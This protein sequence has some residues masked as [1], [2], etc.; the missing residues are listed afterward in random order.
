MTLLGER[1]WQLPRPLAW[2][3][4]SRPAVPAAPAR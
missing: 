2:L 4:R 3:P 1:N